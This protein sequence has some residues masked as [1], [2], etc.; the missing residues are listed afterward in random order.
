MQKAT[1]LLY[2]GIALVLSA[3]ALRVF[4]EVD[5]TYFTVLLFALNGIGLTVLGVSLRENKKD[6]ALARSPMAKMYRTSHI[7]A[8]VL[9]V[10]MLLVLIIEQIL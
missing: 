6:I 5:A 2:I 8:L 1:V 7:A 10:L 4:S 3:I 9:A